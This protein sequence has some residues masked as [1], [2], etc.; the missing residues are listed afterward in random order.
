MQRTSETIGTLAAALAKAQLQL[1]NPEKSLV[2]TVRKDGGEEETFRYA[3]LSSGLEIVRK[4]LGDHE[5]ATVQTT[6]IDQTS[7]TVNLTTVLAHASGEWIASDWPVCAISET[8]TP[9]R[10]GAALTYARRYALF[11]LVGISGEDDIDAP[12][13]AAPTVDISGI[14]KPPVGKNAQLNGGQGQSAQNTPGGRGAKAVWKAAKP[15]LGVEASAALRDRLMVDLEAIASSDD[16]AAWAHRILGAKNT[17]T[18]V[19]AR[20]I[21]EAFQAKLA[22][23]GSAADISD[24]PLSPM[25]SALQ[26]S[27]SSQRRLKGHVRTSIAEG[28]DKSLLAH[29]EPR[30]VRDK[31]HVRFV[32]KQPCLICGRR[33]CDSHHLRF[34]QHRALARKVSD[35]FTVPLCRGHHREVHRY[36]D[37]AAWWKKVGIDPRES[38]R[39]LWLKTHPLPM[40]P[41]KMSIEGTTPVAAVGAEQRNGKRDRSIEKRGRKYKTKPIIAADTSPAVSKRTPGI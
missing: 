40:T 17:L 3:S 26:S 27:A 39:S 9:H 38:A 23:F 41:D 34:A 4:T 30:R 6:S 32:A 35:E 33:P 1:T 29:P 21:E 13:L 16:A 19:D 8:K 7:G 24:V 31:D 15:I 11:T 5:I 28:I 10:M 14:K 2:A 36:G 25:V 37:E 22:K 20:Q 12:D 18:A